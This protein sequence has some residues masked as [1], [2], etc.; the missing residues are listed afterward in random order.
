M[1]DDFNQMADRLIAKVCDAIPF[2]TDED[3]NC[4]IDDCI[5]ALERKPLPPYYSTAGF[6]FPE[7]PDGGCY[8][9]MSLHYLMEIIEERKL[10]IPD[11]LRDEVDK[12]FLSNGVRFDWDKE[13]FIMN[14][15]Y[16]LEE[17]RISDLVEYKNE[18]EKRIA[19]CESYALDDDFSKLM[20]VK[21]TLSK[22]SG[23]N[24]TR[25]TQ[26]PMERLKMLIV[27]NNGKD[28]SRSQLAA[29]DNV[30]P[31]DEE[32]GADAPVRSNPESHEIRNMIGRNCWTDQYDDNPDEYNA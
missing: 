15:F 31:D 26:T 7:F 8:L 32:D 27:L 6:D 1:D 21:A 5:C 9:A 13:R 17:D 16:V 18:L 19:K 29:F 11:E 4:V 23:G 14:S 20:H 2:S 12:F 25:E 22:I 10:S 3:F 28:F 24:P 30:D